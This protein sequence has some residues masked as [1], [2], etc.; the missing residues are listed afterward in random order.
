[1]SRLQTWIENTGQY[2]WSH[3]N[4]V[5][6]QPQE[7]RP[8]RCSVQQIS[9]GGA[10]LTTTLGSIFF[11]AARAAE[12]ITSDL[13]NRISRRAGTAPQ[14]IA[15]IPSQSA[16]PNAPFSL[17][18]SPTEHFL[19][20]D[21]AGFKLKIY[22][23]NTQSLPNWLNSGIEGI[24]S[25]SAFNTAGLASGVDII[26][27]FAYVT[28]ET[29]LL[30]IDVSDPHNPTLTGACT[31]PGFAH[32]VDIVGNFAY[33]ADGTTGGGNY[34]LQIIDISNPNNPTLAGSYTTP[35]NAQEIEV[36]GNY[37][38]LIDAPY[39]LDPSS[40]LIIDVSNPNSP[41]LTGSYTTTG[42]AQGVDII[43]NFAYVADGPS[44]LLI[45]DITNRNNPTL[46]GSYDTPGNAFGVNVIGNFAYV[47]DYDFGLQII[48]ISNPNSPTLT[49][50]YNTPGNAY[51]VKVYNNFAYVV[52]V[53]S[54]QIIDVSDPNNPTL[55]RIYDQSL[56]SGVSIIDNFIYAIDFSFGLYILEQS[57]LLSGVPRPEDI[58]NYELEL[59]AEDPDLNQISSTFLLRVEGAPVT[60]GA[61]S[62]KLANVGTF[63]N[64]F[65]DQSVFFDPNGDIIYYSAK[66]TNQ[67][68]LPAWLNFSPIGI[69]SGTPLA[70]DTGTYDIL[71]NA[72][73]GIALAKAN[74]T[75]SLSIDH[76]PQVS[77]PISNQ[78]ANFDAPYSF[79]IPEQTFTD[80][81]V[82]DTLTYSANLS[83]GA[84]LPSWLIF[85]SLTRTF[86]GTPT[87]SDSGSSTISVTATDNPG[88]TVS[89]TFILT[90]GEFPTLLTPISN[91]L[92]VVNTP[93]LFPIPGN[94]FTTPPGEFLTY[95]A[96]KADD[97]LLPPWLDFID[98]TLE[99]QGT[100]LQSDRGQISLKVTAEDSK[101]GSA[102]SYFDLDV[103]DALSHEAARIGGSFVYAIPN[104]M[105][106]SPQGPVTYAV[107]LGDGSP[108]PAWLNFNPTTNI[109]SGVPPSNSEG[110]YS[111]LVTADDGVQAPAL[112]IF[113]LT[114]G[115]NAA[116]K[117]QNPISNQVAQVGQTFRLA[118]TDNTFT[119][120]NDDTLELSAKRA[121]GRALPAWL[122]FTDRTLE[123]KP[124][125]DDTGTFDDQTVPLQICATDGGQEACSV[126]DL[127]VQGLS[128][129]ETA[130]A[131][132]GPLVG[133]AGLAFSW[134]NKRGVILNPWNR[135]NYD[136]GT[137]V[138][139]I[140]QQFT[141]EFEAPKKQIKLVKAFEGQ[142]ML[143]N[144]PAPKALDKKGLINWLKYDKPVG[145][146]G[147]LPSWLEYDGGENMLQSS[148]GPSQKDQGLYTIRAYGSG[149]VILEEVKID[150]GGVSSRAVEMYEM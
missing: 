149:E 68:V 1:M 57:L 17:T 81:D 55:A 97:S 2:F 30:I 71:V 44:G 129:T 142:R 103:V 14:A 111:I 53:S 9:R 84:P 70:S 42:N 41:T 66:Q 125:P 79:T 69:F 139:S 119:D 134:F 49:G 101:G 150:V 99:F 24:H 74:T 140:G 78:A 126:F 12:P 132:I 85:N 120:A 20:S 3:D 31:T 136:K 112:G 108:L 143:W 16:F 22:E 5:E 29:S 90:V 144:L 50:S 45:I 115:Q 109:V 35:G 106:S 100:P 27:H 21:S 95:Y 48:D 147:L 60:T 96:A 54:L 114:V 148:S 102:T 82:D 145:G 110:I 104:E 135:K 43:G 67:G 137:K 107:T 122:T 59:I 64:H 18:V 26:D 75:F 92:V 65:I 138:V 23:K 36:I 62:N 105:I 88:A 32:G 93:Y 38:Y 56:V 89:T 47:A 133:A 141:H 40:L 80:Q 131:I 83:G 72:Y 58:G 77:V 76:F 46:V 25:L 52:D 6:K 123:G 61:I 34:G 87:S 13:T 73:D 121:N 10:L 37:A 113:S 39:A 98:S 51:E 91:Q 4:K 11:G 86:S 94:T 33:V 63:Y 128:N 130:L 117:V 116:P 7:N 19:D 127:S 8:R 28:D 15:T 124:G 146:G 118:V